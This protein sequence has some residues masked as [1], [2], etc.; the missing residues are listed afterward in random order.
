VTV[1]TRVVV[2]S[3]PD[4]TERRAAFAE[5]A[6]GTTLSWSFFDAHRELGP[7]LTYDPEEAIIAKGRPMFPGELGCYSSH[8]YAW[9]EFL[10][11][12]LHQ[13]IVLEDDTIVDWAFLRKLA[14]VDF[15]AQAVPY[16]RLFARRP[17]AFR[18]Y[19]KVVEPQRYLV[20]FVDY[21]HGTQAYVLTRDGA[22][23]FVRHCRTVRRPVDIELDRSWD[24]GVPCLSVFPFPVI[25]VSAMSNIGSERWGRFETPRRLRG[26]RFRARVIERARRVGHRLRLLGPARSPASGWL[27][28][29]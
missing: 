6:R 21:A 23:R 22:E 27:L 3:L 2:I 1:E 9:L 14:A 18:L 11:S 25:E 12:G 5:R 19:G 20:E 8:Y 7:A 24:H 10:E 15:Q 16:L 28:A 4:A 13:M 17:C 29:P 26:R